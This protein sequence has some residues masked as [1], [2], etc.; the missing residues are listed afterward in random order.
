[1]PRRQA[2]SILEHLDATG[3]TR[4]QGDTRILAAESSS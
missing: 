4:R 2:I 3:V 1:L